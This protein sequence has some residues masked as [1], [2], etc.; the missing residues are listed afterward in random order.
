MQ[1][2]NQLE[3]YC[4]IPLSNGFT[5]FQKYFFKIPEKKKCCCNCIGFS[6][7]LFKGHYYVPGA[8]SDEYILVQV[9]IA[10]EAGL[11]PS[12][13]GGSWRMN[14]SPLCSAGRYVTGR[15]CSPLFPARRPSSYCHSSPTS[16]PLTPSNNGSHPPTVYSSY[17][18]WSSGNSQP[19]LKHC[20]K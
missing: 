7:V 13:S 17:L 4:M 18:L 19:C 9:I 11:G 15:S 20:P 2:C 6:F 16:V 10:R 3:P 5:T 1:R 8:F 14:D 12:C